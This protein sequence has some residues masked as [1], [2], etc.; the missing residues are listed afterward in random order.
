MDTP[1][2][3]ALVY[4]ASP[5]DDIGILYYAKYRC[6]HCSALTEDSGLAGYTNDYDPTPYYRFLSRCKHCQK[7]AWV[8][9]PDK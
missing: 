7:S 4:Q 2:V 5:C 6:P 1:T 3:N 8:L 9:N